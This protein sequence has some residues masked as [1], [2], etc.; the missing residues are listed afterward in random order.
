[1]AK[2]EK[3]CAKRSN[4]QFSAPVAVSP[5]RRCKGSVYA[6]D[7]RI[8]ANS[9]DAVNAR[10]GDAVDASAGDAAS[11]CAEDPI[12]RG[13]RGSG[14]ESAGDAEMRRFKALLARY[15]PVERAILAERARR[16]ESKRRRAAA[17]RKAFGD[18]CEMT[19][20]LAKFCRDRGITLEEGERIMNAFRPSLQAAAFVAVFQTVWLGASFLRKEL[21]RRIDRAKHE[22]VRPHYYVK[23]KAR[24]Q[25]LAQ[26]RRRIRMRMTL[27]RCPTREEILDAWVKV[28]ESNEALLRF[29]SLMED[30]E[31]YVDNSLRRTEDGVIVGRRSGIKGWLQM[32]IPAL[33]LKY[34]T[35]MAYKAAAKRMRQVLDISD[36]MPLS[37]VLGDS[38]RRSGNAPATD[39]AKR[40]VP[41]DGK[42]KSKCVNC[43]IQDYGA[44]EICGNSGCDVRRGLCEADELDLLRARAVYLEVVK[45]VGDGVRRQAVLVARLKSLTNPDMV[46]ECN[47]LESWKAKYKHKI[48]VWTKSIWKQR[49]ME[50]ADTRR[51]G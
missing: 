30:L 9:V 13:M 7:V 35:V 31:C 5:V 18:L 24:R 36:P 43:D 47:M 26:E 50:V 39:G 3:D 41:A 16:A 22:I 12:A 32:E 17:R 8:A 25:A 46:E 23:E 20:G 4:T 34:T 29:G 10:V 45:S 33:Y 1:M 15:E 40:R 6:A 51:T 11:R 14:A 42:G 48:T 27:N 28:K 19:E 44:D 38:I 37:A 21:T 49:L 2:R